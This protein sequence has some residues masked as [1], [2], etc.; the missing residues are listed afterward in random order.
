MTA[1]LA[2]IFFPRLGGRLSQSHSDRHAV[3]DNDLIHRAAG[4]YDGPVSYGAAQNAVEVVMHTAARGPHASADEQGYG[5]GPRRDGHTL[6]VAGS[7]RVPGDGCLL[8]L[9]RFSL[10]VFVH[11][12]EQ[13]PVQQF[14]SPDVG[15]VLLVD[16]H[17]GDVLGGDLHLR[18]MWR[19]PEDGAKQL[20]GKRGLGQQTS[21]LAKP[22]HVLF[23]YRRHPRCGGD[24]AVPVRHEVAH[25]VLANSP[26]IFP[27][28]QLLKA[29]R[30]CSVEH[31]G[32]RVDLDAGYRLRVLAGAAG[33]WSLFQ[34]ADALPGLGQ[35]GGQGHTIRP[36]THDNK[37][38]SLVSRHTSLLSSEFCASMF[39]N[40]WEI[41]RKRISSQ[42]RSPAPL[43]LFPPL[44]TTILHFE[45]VSVTV[46][47][48]KPSSR[49]Q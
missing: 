31:D 36:A 2:Q 1:F 47:S 27:Q 35:V 38:V 33:L 32:M 8:H 11:H 34:N 44:A 39:G 48:T 4:A 19:G 49:R 17:V 9:P 43:S 22:H 7:A 12:V 41:Q 16:L 15:L 5:A 18:W 30:W 10:K 3:V 24:S 23:T 6:P 13:V 45:T 46:R 42:T 25:L 21:H 20:F 26:A 14:L 40:C 37:I 28:L 29:G